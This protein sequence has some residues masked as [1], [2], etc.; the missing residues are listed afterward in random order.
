LFFFAWCRTWVVLEIASGHFF[1]FI[2]KY[3]S[4]V[5]FFLFLVSIPKGR[6]LGDTF[7]VSF[8]TSQ[9]PLSVCWD[10][11]LDGLKGAHKIHFAHKS[12]KNNNFG[13][14]CWIWVVLEISSRTFV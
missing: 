6:H 7:E 2:F 9:G 1:N 3:Q 5:D 13:A 11:W 4:T 14:S 12:S 8:R 10:S